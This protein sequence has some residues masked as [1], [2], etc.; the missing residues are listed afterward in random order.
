MNIETIE[1]K[2]FG[3]VSPKQG[4]NTRSPYAH[5]KKAMENLDIINKSG[6]FSTLVVLPT[7]EEKH[8]RHPHGC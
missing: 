4:M 1:T 7:G 6:S 8:T 2:S 3:V 5:Q